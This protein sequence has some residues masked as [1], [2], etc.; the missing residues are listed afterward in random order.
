MN[1]APEAQKLDAA[2]L[3]EEALDTDA[4]KEGRLLLV[5]EQR[6]GETRVIGVLTAHDLLV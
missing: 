2:T 1:P 4:L 6:A 5:T 3:V